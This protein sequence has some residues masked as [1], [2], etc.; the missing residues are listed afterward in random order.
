VFV[1]LT[2]SLVLVLLQ[3]KAALGKIKE[4]RKQLDR[5]PPAELSY[6]TLRRLYVRENKPS[7][8]KVGFDEKAMVAELHFQCSQPCRFFCGD[9]ELESTHGR[10][11]VPFPLAGGKEVASKTVKVV[12]E[13]NSASVTL[14]H[15]PAT[16]YGRTGKGNLILQTTLRNLPGQEGDPFAQVNPHKEQMVKMFDAEALTLPPQQRTLN[17]LRRLA[18][19]IAASPQNNP[20]STKWDKGW[21]I[22]EE[23]Q[24]GQSCIDCVGTSV[25]G[26]DYLLAAGIQARVIHLHGL[27]NKNAE[28][29]TVQRSESHST[30]EVFATGRW[31]WFDLSM[32]VL[33]VRMAN[34]SKW[35]S[36]WE[37]F[38]QLETPE[39]QRMLRFAIFDPAGKKTREVTLDE[40]PELRNLILNYLTP[41]KV[42]QFVGLSSDDSA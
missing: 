6:R 13:G 41:D 5:Q 36:L 2:G 16:I 18:E 3:F 22:M 24:K 27:R 23:V 39:T 35:L 33:Y 1:I 9:N 11:K 7:L 19:I 34:D 42:L 25:I 8:I 30:N 15:Y 14:R 4:L 40:S 31:S 12:W 38:H 26:R 21:E 37:V 20:L 32:K 29:L 17:V 28:G 10:V